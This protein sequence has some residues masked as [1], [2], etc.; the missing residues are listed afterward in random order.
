M[1]DDHRCRAEFAR[2]GVD[3]DAAD[4]AVIAV[5]GRGQ[6][7]QYLVENLAAPAVGGGDDHGAVPTAWLLPTN[8]N[9]SWYPGRYNASI[10]VNQLALEHAMADVDQVV[11]ELRSHGLAADQIV[12]TGY[13]QGACVMA[14]YLRHHPDRWAGVAILGG[15]LLGPKN[16]FKQVEGDFSNVQVSFVCGDR[17]PCMDPCAAWASAHA[18][19][20]AGASAVVTVYPSAD[21][22]LGDIERRLV[23]DLIVGAAGRRTNVL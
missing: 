5:H 10:N 21:H 4:V 3:L 6:T 23:A 7:P 12:L 16:R 17:D 22:T 13:S 1:N 14:E 20:S 8:P 2:F 18:F 19:E 11:V 15:A 9:R